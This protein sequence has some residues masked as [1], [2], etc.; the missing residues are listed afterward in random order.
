MPHKDA[1]NQLKVSLQH[2]IITLAANGWSRRRIARELGIDR[3]TVGKYLRPD[4]PKTAIS[5]TGSS[6]ELSSKP[7][8]SLTGCLSAGRQSLCVPWQEVIDLAVRAGLSAH[9]LYQDLVGGYQFH[10]DGI[11]G[12]PHGFDFDRIPPVFGG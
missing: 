1:M 10:R 11:A 4:P 12:S 5:L 3:E 2:S 6:P 7:A 9:R 8:I